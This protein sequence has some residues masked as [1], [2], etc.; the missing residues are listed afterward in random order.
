[1]MRRDLRELQAQGLVHVRSVWSGPRSKELTVVVLTKQGK[2]LLKEHGQVTP[3][4]AIHSGFVKPREVRHDAAIYRMFQAEKQRIERAGG[5]VRR[6][7]LDYELKKKVYSPLAKAKH[8]PPLD[9]ARKQ[10]EIAG[11][12]GL[13]VI[14][15]KIP[16]PDLRIEYETQD[17]DVARVDLE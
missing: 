5:L 9:Y 12:N 4:Q 16:L 1:D 11:Q 8:L 10:A 13:K 17:G 7:V 14:D 3:G 6:V 15:G 2:Q